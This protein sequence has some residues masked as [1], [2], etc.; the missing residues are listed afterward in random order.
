MFRAPT[1]V[2][3]RVVASFERLS[4]SLPTVPIAESDADFSLD[5]R[6]I[7]SQGKELEPRAPQSLGTRR[8]DFVRS[9]EV[10]CQPLVQQHVSSSKYL[11]VEFSVWESD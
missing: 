8:G 3:R 10:T 7:V 4:V 1:P 6:L 11:K 5:V 2:A 9:G